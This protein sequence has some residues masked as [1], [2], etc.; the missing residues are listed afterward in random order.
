MYKKTQDYLNYINNDLMR[1][2]KS[3]TDILPAIKAQYFLIISS[4]AVFTEGLINI[5]HGSF[6]YC[7]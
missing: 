6:L 5:V 3:I 2:K 7:Q 1:Y 4:T